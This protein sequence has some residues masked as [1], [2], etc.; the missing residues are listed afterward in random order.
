ME[1]KSVSPRVPGFVFTQFEAYT[2]N[3]V[4]SRYIDQGHLGRF[5]EVDQLTDVGGST[6]TTPV[7]ILWLRPCDSVSTDMTMMTECTVSNKCMNE[8]NGINSMQWLWE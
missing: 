3:A 1:K 6:T 7:I 4:R 8:F 5:T 2:C